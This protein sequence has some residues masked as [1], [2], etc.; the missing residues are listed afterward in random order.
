MKEVITLTEKVSKE[1]VERISS[2]HTK[3]IKKFHDY[4]IKFIKDDKIKERMNYVFENITEYIVEVGTI[5]PRTRDGRDFSIPMPK[6][7]GAYVVK[8]ITTKVEDG[9]ECGIITPAV[10]VLYDKLTN[11]AD[12]IH[13]LAHAFS[14]MMKILFENGAIYKCGLNCEVYKDTGYKQANGDWLNE[15]LTDAIASLFFEENRVEIEKDCG[16]VPSRFIR[17]LSYP[18][19]YDSYQ[20][21]KVMLCNMSN[22][23]LVNAYLGDVEDMQK[24]A[25]DF[26]KVMQDECVTFKELNKIRN[27][28]EGA[29]KN[30]LDYLAC[31]Y[32]LSKCKTLEEK[33]KALENMRKIYKFSWSES[34][35][36]K[37]LDSVTV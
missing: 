8:D 11:P 30:L 25:G 15:G 12:F 32:V 18:A 13:E 17:K 7:N 33:D 23:L 20:A 2:L 3:W 4:L 14:S 36:Q 27:N 28:D 29:D 22:E 6:L 5:I 37:L 31:K 9:K 16:F 19:S 24:F 1:D 21:M 35:E 10:A 26:D 34:F